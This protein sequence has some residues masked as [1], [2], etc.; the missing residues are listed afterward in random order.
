MANLGYFQFKATPGVYQLA[1]RPGRGTEVFD[2]KSVGAEG[3]DSPGVEVTGYGVSLTSF[4]GV[5]ILPRFER[6]EGMERE[7][8]LVDA[9]P[10]ALSASFAGS[11]VSR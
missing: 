8:V 11:V 2:M 10:A 4:E 6:R 7:N 1:I 5:T 3:W 9:P